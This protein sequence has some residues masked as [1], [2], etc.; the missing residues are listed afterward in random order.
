MQRN[1]F[2]GKAEIGLDFRPRA[3]AQS[4][5]F[6][7]MP[8][9]ILTLLFYI[10]QARPDPDLAMAPSP[11]PFPATPTP[12][13]VATTGLAA[14]TETVNPPPYLHIAQEI[15]EGA[16]LTFTPADRWTEPEKE[17]VREMALRTGEAFADEMNLDLDLHNMTG[18]V[19]SER[20]FWLVFGGTVE[21]HRPGHSC[22][23]SRRVRG[24]EHLPCNAGVWGETVGGTTILVF[25]QVTPSQ[26]LKNPRWIVHELGHAF[27]N[28]LE[29]EPERAV[30]DS[31]LSRSIFAGPLGVWQFSL[32]QTQGEVFADLFL[33]WVFD[34]WGEDTNGAEFMQTNMNEWILS[35]I[36]KHWGAGE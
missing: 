16:L 31:L 32:A 26:I 14:P 5:F 33:G 1:F 35:A 20:A 18:Q 9:L 36:K 3:V 27:S 24:L 34:T 12:E 8:T 2:L 6:T 28:G 23:E 15:G 21:L 25:E 11:T 10:D 7:L 19:T 17:V 30:P 22:D 13:P 29:K 4:L